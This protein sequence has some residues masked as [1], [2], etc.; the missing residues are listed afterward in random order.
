MLWDFQNVWKRHLLPGFSCGHLIRV[1]WPNGS[2]KTKTRILKIQVQRTSFSPPR[3]VI[4]IV[5]FTRGD[6]VSGFGCQVSATEFDPL[7]RSRSLNGQSFTRV[8]L[9][10]LTN[11]CS[12]FVISRNLTPDTINRFDLWQ[13]RSSLTWLWRPGFRFLI[14][15]VPHLPW[16][17]HVSKTPQTNL[18]KPPRAIWFW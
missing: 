15:D 8:G 5:T 16:V 17:F 13:S 14:N 6:K 7:C 4:Y 18:K 2:R 3:R 11:W 12:W 10:F 1:Y 9:Q